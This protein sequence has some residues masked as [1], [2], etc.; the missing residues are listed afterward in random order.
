[1]KLIMEK[2]P[3]ICVMLPTLLKIRWTDFLQKWFG[4]TKRRNGDVAIWFIG[5]M[6]TF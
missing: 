1:M 3:Q 2:C 5:E 6:R 4:G